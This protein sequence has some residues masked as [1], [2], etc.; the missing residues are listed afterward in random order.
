[1]TTEEFV[2]CMIMRGLT[3]ADFDR[4]TYGMLINYA[5]GYDRVKAI[6]RGESVPDEDAQYKQLKAIEPLVEQQFEDGHI[7]AKDY[8]EYKQSLIEYERG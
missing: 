3:V 1:M 7:T 2:A 5:R 4:F 6:S 8:K